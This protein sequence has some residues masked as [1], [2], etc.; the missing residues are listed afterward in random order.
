MVIAFIIIIDTLSFGRRLM[1]S[2]EC[3]LTVSLKQNNQATGL[4]SFN[5]YQTELNILNIFIV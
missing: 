2:G 1:V 3:I 4:L 5:E